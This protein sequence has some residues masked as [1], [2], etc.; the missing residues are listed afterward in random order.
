M[1]DFRRGAA[2]IAAS[3]EKPVGSGSYRSYAPSIFWNENDE[4]KH[5]LFLNNIDD[6]PT[7]DM[8]RYIPQTRKL[9][10]GTEKTFYEEVIARTDRGIGESVDPMARD[11]DGQIKQNQL[12]VAVELEPVVEINEDNGRQ[13][14]VGF[15][16][17]TRTF[18]R[19]I[20]DED[21]DLTEEY[22][23]VVAPEIGF[24]VQSPHNFYNI[25]RSSDANDGPIDEIAQRITRVGKDSNTT[26]TFKP[27]ETLT[28]DLT[29]LLNN[30]DGITYLDQDERDALAEY[31]SDAQDE[32]E[33]YHAIGYALLDK[34]LAELAD[35]DRYDSL[36]NTI[37]ES[38]DRFGN[39]AKKKKANAAAKKDAPK[40]ERPSR[41]SSRRAKPAAKEADEPTA[42]ETEEKKPARKP[43]AKKSEDEPADPKAAALQKLHDLRTKQESRNA[44]S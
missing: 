24:V 21:G 3:A 39:K 28:V 36:Y 34:R 29:N 31:V 15:E 14:V 18:E 16:V 13:N 35:E 44:A 8:V 2:A 41:P 20:R 23:E 11:W 37:T 19:R 25:L 5:V 12:A 33:A 43:R 32:Y 6:I 1:P 22:E 26:Y 27:F 9:A 30:I 40:R 17:A 42:D 7:L 10:D 4:T 38:L